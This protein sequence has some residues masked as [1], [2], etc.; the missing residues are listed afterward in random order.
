MTTPITISVVR[1]TRQGQGRSGQVKAGSGQGRSDQGRAGSGQV[2]TS[3]GQGRS[4]QVRFGQVRLTGEM[5]S[6]VRLTA[7]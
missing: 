7:R 6:M 5:R 4:G 1:C 2:S 3:S